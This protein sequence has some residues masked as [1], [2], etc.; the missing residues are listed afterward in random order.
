LKKEGKAKIRLIGRKWT[1]APFG[2]HRTTG[3]AK[4]RQNE[5]EKAKIRGRYVM[6]ARRTIGIP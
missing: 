4:R 5:G 6:A 2:S 1:K 3:N